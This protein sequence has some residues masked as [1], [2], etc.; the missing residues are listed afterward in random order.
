MRIFFQHQPYLTQY[1]KD[2]KTNLVALAKVMI[3]P[4]AVYVN[5]TSRVKLSGLKI[6]DHKVVG[7]ESLATNKFIGAKIGVPNDSVNEGRALNILQGYG[8]LSLESGVAYPTKKHIL[9]NPYKLEIVE[10]DAALLP[11]VLA[12]KNLDLAVINSNYALSAKLNLKKDAVFVERKDSP[13]ANVLVVRSDDLNKPKMKALAKVLN[14]LAIK[15][16]IE[17]KYKG[18]VIPAF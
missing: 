9:T 18:A 11:R 1:N 16:F 4:M 12:T 7:V 13:F 8:L 15:E 6:V 10:L 17:D 2:H 5:E 14:S 3:A